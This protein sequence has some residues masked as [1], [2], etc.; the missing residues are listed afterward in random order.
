MTGSVDRFGH[1]PLPFMNF[2]QRAR[3]MKISTM[4]TAMMAKVWIM[5]GSL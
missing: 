3:M 1:F 2:V 4:T 5:A